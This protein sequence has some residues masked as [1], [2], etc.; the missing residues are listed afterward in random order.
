M[1]SYLMDGLKILIFMNPGTFEN[2]QI[3]R[4]T[5]IYAKWEELFHTVEFKDFDGTIITSYKI[6]HSD[7]FISSRD[8]YPPD[9]EGYVFIGWSHD[10]KN[11][12]TDLIIVA[13]YRVI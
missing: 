9:K 7:F 1:V 5:T 8:V 4:N 2:N 12:T 10:G 6:I 13:Q 11:I 3:L